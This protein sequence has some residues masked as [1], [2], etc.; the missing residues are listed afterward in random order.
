MTPLVVLLCTLL[1]G[2]GFYFSTGLGQ[3]WFL[4]WLAPL[5]VLWLAFGAF[6]GKVDRVATAYE[7]FPS[8]NATKQR[9]GKGWIV[10]LAAWGAGIIGGCNLLPAYLGVMPLPVLLLAIAGPALLF[11]LAVLGARFVGRKLSPL[12]GVIAFATLWTGFDYLQSL[13]ADGAAL[14]PAYSQV[15]FPLLI[16]SASLAGPWAITCLIGLVC[17]ALAMAG[18]ARK[19]SF[20][21]L[22]AAVF[23]LNAGYGAWRIA[24]APK[25][26]LLRVGLAADDGLIAT[27]LKPDEKSAL[28]VVQAYADAGRALAH[29]DANLI[30]FPEKIA[31]LET[32][33]RGDVKA[34]LETVAHIGHATL[35]A[36]FDDREGARQNIAWIFFGNGAPPAIYAKRHLVPGLESGFVPGNASFMLSDRTAVA[37]CKDMDFPAGL[38]RDAMLKPT[39]LAV[40]AWDFGA[41]ASWHARGAILR[42]VEN[43]FAVVRAANQGLLTVSD[44][45]GRVLA[46]KR[47]GDGMVLLRGSVPRGPGVTLYAK[48]G[49]S[50][51][52]LCLGMS[53]LL[54][55]AGFF[56]AKRT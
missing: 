5:P 1:S 33:W 2:A 52:W 53:L 44:A 24:A 56:A 45:Y 37:I 21:L 15:P 22:A 3:L 28:A 39:L 27:G 11:A 13:G 6:S 49:D 54:L 18:A 4:A 42:G 50:L 20:A 9:P 31:V 17:A 48:T 41:D 7:R 34:E 36:G 14:S 26:P 46:Q 43:G 23:A 38:R 29:Q 32:P 55:A 12:A 16:Q 51:A 10:F 25:T 19:A 47:S 30:V 40:P 8:E 35:I